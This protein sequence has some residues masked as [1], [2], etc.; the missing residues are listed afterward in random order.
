MKK[1]NTLYSFQRILYNEKACT[2]WAFHEPLHHE[3][4][5]YSCEYTCWCEPGTYVRMRLIDGAVRH[6]ALRLATEQLFG[7]WCG[8]RLPAMS[9]EKSHR[10]GPKALEP[11]V[12]TPCNTQ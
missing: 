4:P 7:D 10:T 3:E 11:W 6:M 9:T 2:C 12:L 8:N 1:N 5:I